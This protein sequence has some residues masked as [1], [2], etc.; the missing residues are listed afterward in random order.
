MLRHWWGGL[1][2]GGVGMLTFLAL[3][4]MLDATQLMG[5]DGHVPCTCT[6]VGMLRNWWGGM[7]SGF[8]T[9][10]WEVIGK[11][12][13]INMIGCNLGLEN[14]VQCFVNISTTCETPFLQLLLLSTK[15]G[16]SPNSTCA[17]R[18]KRARV[19]VCFQKNVFLKLGFVVLY[20][21]WI[22]WI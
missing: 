8:E 21:V 20:Y 10:H 19:A 5:W 22:N 6:H 16:C 3:A 12:L 11:L 2:W 1:G 9:C 7:G 15:H 17:S 14:V 4:H 18:K 13:T